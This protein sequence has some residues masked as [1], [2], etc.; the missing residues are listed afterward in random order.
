MFGIV[1]CP[2]LSFYVIA[3]FSRCNAFLNHSHYF[4]EPLFLP[5]SAGISPHFL[6]SHL[7]MGTRNLCV[8]SHSS[9]LCTSS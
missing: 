6:V 3:F 8:R 5:K 1:E 7:R 4:F 9:A 2:A